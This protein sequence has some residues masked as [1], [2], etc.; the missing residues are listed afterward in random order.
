MARSRCHAI[1]AGRLGPPEPPARRSCPGC[2]D[3]NGAARP[4]RGWF[5]DRKPVSE[6]SA[7]QIRQRIDGSAV[8][9]DLEVQAWRCGEIGRAH[10]CTPV[11]NAHLVC[12]L[13]LETKKINTIKK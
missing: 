8:A 6:S 12:R 13:L 9:P 2:R 5:Q 11:T 4:H 3:S 1:R 10:V 7:R